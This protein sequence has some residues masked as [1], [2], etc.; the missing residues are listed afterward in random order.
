MTLELGSVILQK[1]GCLNLRRLPFEGRLLICDMDG[2]LLDSNSEIS[3]D[4][5]KAIERF[6]EGGGLFT[7]ATGRMEKSVQPYLNRLPVNA[8]VIVYNGAGIFDFKAGR[9]LWQANLDT[10]ITGPV[11]DIMDKFPGIS[12][13]VYHGGQTY[14]VTENQ[15]SDALRIREH[16]EPIRTGLDEVPT[17]WFKII[18]AWDPLKLKN[19]EK[20]LNSCQG[21][22]RQVYSEPQFLELLN[23]KATKGSAMNELIGMLGM[24]GSCV[25]SMGDNLNDIELIKEA[26][27]GIA[28]ANAH[29]DLKAVADM[30]STDNNNSAA[31]EVIGW[32]EEGKILL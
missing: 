17:P 25:I 3:S 28:V 21:D 23:P 32:L 31:A 2:T 16:F 12:V 11:K 13:Q 7:V 20:F 30:C 15:Y 6:I 27:I 26:G 5:I 18:L 14:F 1:K 9:I 29:T 24:E 22:F 8:P 10:K 4:N 19:V